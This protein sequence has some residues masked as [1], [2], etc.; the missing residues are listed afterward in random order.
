MLRSC[1]DINKLLKNARFDW[2]KKKTLEKAWAE[3]RN[4]PPSYQL[5]V[6]IMFINVHGSHRS[7]KHL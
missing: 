4:R 5:C 6:D 3:S 2:L 7:E 1:S